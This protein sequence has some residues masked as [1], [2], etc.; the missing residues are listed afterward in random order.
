[1]VDDDDSDLNRTLRGL[2]AREY[3]VLKKRFGIYVSQNSSRD[4][5]ARQFEITRERIRAIEERAK[6]KL[7]SRVY[8]VMIQITGYAGD[9]FPGIVSC[10]LSDA[11]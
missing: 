7:K 1:M 3:E 6:K 5:V 9:D 11:R 8:A 10:E 2:S 4:D